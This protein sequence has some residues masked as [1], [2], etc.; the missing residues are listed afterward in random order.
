VPRL[1]ENLAVARERGDVW[2]LTEGLC[3]L[4]IVQGLAGD[5]R[6]ARTT[7][8]EALA[9]ADAAGDRFERRQALSVEAWAAVC[10]GDLAAAGRGAE[11][12]IG[13]ARA[14]QDTHTLILAL[15]I[16]G[17][18]RTYQ[19][20]AA[21]ARPPADEAVRIALESGGAWTT[22]ALFGRAVLAL[23]DGDLATLDWACEAF[24]QA[25]VAFGPPAEI[26]LPWL[27][28][29]QLLAG[30]VEAARRLLDP[31]RP[32]QHRFFESTRLAVQATV[33][34]V[35]GEPE[36][37]E[38]AAHQALALAHGD[39]QLICEVES[40]EALAG[41]DVD[42]GAHEQA[43]RLLGAVDARRRALG[44]ARLPMAQPVHDADV[45]AVVAA[46]GADRHDALAAEGAQMSWD[47]T[48]DYVTR[49]RGGRKRPASG[50]ASLTPTELSVVRLVAEGLSNQ[51][52]AE[53]LFVAPR[54]VGT[55]LT[56]VYAKLGITTRT[57]LAVAALRRQ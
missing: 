35:C 41:V 13:E 56:H 2:W 18:V 21:S 34:R 16:V 14:T 3:N 36:R 10:Q 9:L 7:S 48:I 32:V 29:G 38:D 47:E 20:D 17:L 30:D 51:Q 49:G 23:Y 15:A 11:P 52:V 45:A 8:G 19:G 24:Q 55:H 37:A 57:E 43:A 12:L 26:I 46:L 50:W 53:R 1:I 31:L 28:L 39:G 27:A 44:Y 54:T 25:A 22:F 42:L 4:A 6:Q 33:E 5:F 40:V